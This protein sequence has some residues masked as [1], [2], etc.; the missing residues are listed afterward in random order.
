MRHGLPVQVPLMTTEELD[1]ALQ[2]VCDLV[3]E[4][5][6]LTKQD[7]ES[8]MI[9]VVATEVAAEPSVRRAIRSQVPQCSDRLYTRNTQ[10]PE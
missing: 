1:S 5:S 8:A 9:L 3:E 7:V 6:L 4:T 2:S 10:S